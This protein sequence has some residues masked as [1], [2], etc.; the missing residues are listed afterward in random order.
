MCNVLHRSVIGP[1]VS[2]T[3]Y[4]EKHYRI[5]EGVKRSSYFI[6]ILLRT[7]YIIQLSRAC[8]LG[9]CGNGIVQRYYQEFILSTLVIKKTQPLLYYHMTQL[10]KTHC[11]NTKPQKQLITA[12]YKAF[13]LISDAMIYC[14]IESFHDNPDREAIP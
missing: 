2:R 9:I 3:L 10:A 12:N 13:L 11:H 14:D 6:S 7:G 5:F 4:D 1:M 8:A